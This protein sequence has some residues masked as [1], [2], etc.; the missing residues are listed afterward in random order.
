M[1]MDI[2]E[3]ANIGPTDDPKSWAIRVV[4][5]GLLVGSVGFILL[6]AVGIVA[7]LLTIHIIGLRR[8][9]KRLSQQV[10]SLLQ[11]RQ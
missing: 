9:V 11:Y 10:Q 4:H 3:F 5:Y 7:V 8:E 1:M 6:I 2:F